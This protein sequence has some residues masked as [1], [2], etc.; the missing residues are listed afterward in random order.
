MVVKILKRA[1]PSV[2]PNICLYCHLQGPVVLTP[3]A[4]SKRL[5]VEQMEHRSVLH[6][7]WWS[8]NYILRD[9]K[10]QTFKLIIIGSP[11]L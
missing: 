6:K 8:C 4:D 3:V 5:A 10:Q 11:L 2:K 7:Q 1:T 9:D